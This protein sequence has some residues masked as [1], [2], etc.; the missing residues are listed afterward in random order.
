[1]CLGGG[2]G[3]G[4]KYREPVKYDPGPG[5]ASPPDTVNDKE[6]SN[7]GNYNRDQM[8]STK[9]GDSKVSSQSSKNTGLY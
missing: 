4:Y 6:I 1:M 8:K 7:T 2:G 5:P 9:P 3:G